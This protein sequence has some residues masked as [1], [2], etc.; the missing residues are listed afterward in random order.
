M[1]ITVDIGL[2]PQLRPGK[3]FGVR[4]TPNSATLRWP[5]PFGIG[6]RPHLTQLRSL[7]IASKARV[8]GSPNRD[9]SRFK[10]PRGCRPLPL[11]TSAFISLQPVCQPAFD[12]VIC[13]LSLTG[14]WT[15]DSWQ[16]W[17]SLW[18]GVWAS[19]WS[20]N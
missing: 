4:N 12:I 3:S 8:I 9:P 18:V 20:H 14:Q 15:V 10:P 19:G 13:L 7:G 6:A 11:W 16:A 17:P 5:W 2:R 1:L